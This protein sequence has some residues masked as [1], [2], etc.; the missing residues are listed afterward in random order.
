[1]GAGDWIE[2]GAD[3]CEPSNLGGERNNNVPL[4]YVTVCSIDSPKNGERPPAGPA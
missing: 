2:P 1:M 4:Q 3:A